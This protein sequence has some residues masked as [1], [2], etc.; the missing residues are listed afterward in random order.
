MSADKV[1]PRV[2]DVDPQRRE[3]RVR[4]PAASGEDRFDNNLPSVDYAGGLL[5]LEDAVQ[6]LGLEK[7]H[8]APVHAV[9]Y[10][11]RTRKLRFVKV[12]KTLRFRREW[13]DEYID[14]ESIGPIRRT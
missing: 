7:D 2:S 6:Y 1:A 8:Q 12:G 9:R 4:E 14:T 10:L 5:T 13:L 3:Q 11:C